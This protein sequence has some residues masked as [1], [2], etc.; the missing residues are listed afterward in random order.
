MHAVHAFMYTET[1]L[2]DS[3]PWD[4]FY[5]AATMLCSGSHSL[6]WLYLYPCTIILF[7]PLEQGKSTIIGQYCI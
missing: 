3:K 5:R 4:F 2:A 6:S 1:K 7:L